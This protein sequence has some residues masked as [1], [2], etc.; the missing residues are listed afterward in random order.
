MAM[1]ITQGIGQ[2]S[3]DAVNFIYWKWPTRHHSVF[4]RARF[5]IAHYEVSSAIAFTVVEDRQNM[6]MFQPGNRARF[7]LKAFHKLCAF[8]QLTRQ[9]FDRHMA[10]HGGLISLVDRG[11]APL[12]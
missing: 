6:R 9:H 11:H 10:I 8:S 5:E 7:L 4:E 2:L 1:C 12:A 3:E